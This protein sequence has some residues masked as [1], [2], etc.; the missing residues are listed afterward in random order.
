M[1]VDEIAARNNLSFRKKSKNE[2]ASSESL[3]LAKP[4]LFMNLSG[5]AV[6][7]IESAASQFFYFFFDA[8]VRELLSDFKIAPADF[9]LVVDCLSLPVGAIRLSRGG[10]GKKELCFMNFFFLFC[11]KSFQLLDRT[12]QSLSW[13]R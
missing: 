12:G 10:S 13:Q 1:V 5:E 4:R 11:L 7:Q 8:K 6:R 9:L 3:V 2:V